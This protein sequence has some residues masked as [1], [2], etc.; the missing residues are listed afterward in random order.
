MTM[1]ADIN[2]KRGRRRR[3]TEEEIAAAEADETDL[4][5]ADG[6][7]EDSTSERAI[8][9]KK[10]TPTPGR[11]NRQQTEE[12]EGNI[13]TRS[14]GGIMERLYNVRSELEKVSW[15]SREDVARLFRIVLGVTAVASIVLGSIALAFT[16]L[17]AQ[18]LENPIIFV[19]FFA[20]VGA[21]SFYVYRNLQTGDS[22]D[23][24]P[25]RL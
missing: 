1:S 15:P 7:Y 23:N 2:E 10:G 16:F 21:A 22:T 11:R 6:D 13:V 25:T 4:D 3:R 24:Y 14:T 18:G 5:D 19:V 12:P 17:F 20:L 9:A 8:T